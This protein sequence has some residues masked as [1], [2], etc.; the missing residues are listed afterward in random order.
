MSAVSAAPEL[1]LADIALDARAGGR[2][3]VFTYRLLEPASEG[4]AFLVPLGT[5]AAIGYAVKVYASSAA[6]L[7]F[8]ASKLRDIQSPIAGLTIPESTMAL[9]RFTADAY[10]A[11]LPVVLAAATPPGAL[12]RIS[13]V[14]TV[15]EGTAGSFEPSAL[16]S[17]V[18]AAMRV[19]GGTLV[20]SKGRR[21]QSRTLASLKVLCAKG[22]IS[23]RFELAHLLEERDS[24]QLFRITRND[25]LVASFLRTESKRKPAQALVLMRLEEFDRPALAAPDI[26]A[27]CG[28]TDATVR[29]LLAS[30][31]LEPVETESSA[32]ATAPAP[33][34][35]QALA[36]DAIAESVS[37]RVSRT[38]L[39]Y[40]VTGS[41][42][43]EVYMRAAAEA[44]RLGRQVLYLVPE[45][46][47]A[48]QGIANLRA[49]FG[50]RVAV[51]HSDLNPTERLRNWQAIRAGGAA[52]VLGARSAVFAPLEDIGLIV[53][54]EEH[55]SS[56]K[57][58]TA[59]R[60]HTRRLAEFLSGRH[61][62]P[63]VLG[64]ATPSI[65]SFEDA[66]AER[67]TLLS[68]P[69]RAASA[70]LPRV[71]VEDLREVFKSGHPSIFTE[72]LATRLQETVAS[73]RQAILFLNRRAYS[74]F[75][76]CR[77]CGHHFKCPSCAVS[78][79][80]SR[81][82]GRLRCHHCGHSEAPPEACPSCGGTRMRPL[83]AGT[84]K[85]EEA[86]ADLIP[87]ARVGRLDRDVAQRK[88][89]L[90]KVLGKFASGEIQVL[91][92]TQMVAK[93]LNFPNVTLV[94]VIAADL[95][96][97]IPDF[98]S[99]ERTFQLLSQ[100]AGRA[101]RGSEPGEVVVQT[102]NPDHPAIVC[103]RD[104]DFL[105]FFEE[106][107]R[108]RVGAGYPPFLR[109]ANVV[110]SGEERPLV[111]RAAESALLRLEEALPSATILGPADCAIERLNAKWRQ[112]ILVKLPRQDSPTPIADALAGIDT[113]EVH[114][115]ID[116]DP[117]SLM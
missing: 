107:R 51:L 90:E 82:S 34:R 20:E 42:K 98:R 21:I 92:G 43:T 14:W 66:E 2:E 50:G 115:V 74:P 55:E 3:A 40:G 88:G 4:D 103:A 41:G 59:P 78:L 108:E 36:I 116:I 99:A 1:L 54:D 70:T 79:S 94:G 64:S 45:I 35:H 85:V 25:E 5:R 60:Y 69:E 31:L 17:E 114:I 22:L 83:G 102:F 49:R 7:P 86:V 13:T 100:V 19:A 93:G 112:H 30:G 24:P 72:A 76:L 106:E 47:L 37:T 32:M 67:V 15:E 110:F 52:I 109:L 29:A 28:V 46:A 65:E 48:T 104:H 62:C 11:P 97:S 96:L 105:T 23:R 95:S 16:Q 71:I 81:K 58:E 10:L 44:L 61:G 117:Y 89:A 6:D 18:L 75:L 84:E 101:G 113:K 27:L 77:D 38:F 63:L 73:E 8:D 12:D 9:L 33:N 68:L 26:K 87:N 56:Y 57:Q 91:V 53:M 80:W 111:E 39:L